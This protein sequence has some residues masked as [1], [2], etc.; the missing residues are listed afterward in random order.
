MTRI[1]PNTINDESSRTGTA[2]SRRRITYFCMDDRPLYRV[3]GPVSAPSL[4]DPG[5]RQ[6]RRPVTVSTANRGG[7]DVAHVRLEHQEAVV[8]GHPHAQHLV[9]LA[10][11]DLLGDRPLLVAIGG[12]PQLR[13]QLVDD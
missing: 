1:K 2:S 13:R 3:T 5:P 4:V 11:D 9:E 6:G 7:R 8:V 12:P 10:V